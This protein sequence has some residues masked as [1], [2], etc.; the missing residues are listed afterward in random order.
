MY[1]SLRL[2][3]KAS[4]EQLCEDFDEFTWKHRLNLALGIDGVEGMAYRALN[5]AEGLGYHSTASSPSLRSK[6]PVDMERPLTPMDGNA[7]NVKVVVRVRKFI[8][9]G[10]RYDIHRQTIY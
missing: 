7:G 1:P 4:L 9:R 6:E 5:N 10:M 8:R 2:R 3:S